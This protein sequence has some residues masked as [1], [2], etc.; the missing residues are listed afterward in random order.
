MITIYY[1]TVSYLH[2]TASKDVGTNFVASKNR[3]T[4]LKT[5]TLLELELMLALLPVK[6]SSKFLKVLILCTRGM[7]FTDH[8]CP[9]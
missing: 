4:P 6:L 2:I 1:G 7:I 8:Y 9:R 5:I 3:E